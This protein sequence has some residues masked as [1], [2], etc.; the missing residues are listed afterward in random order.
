[1]IVPFSGELLSS[2][3]GLELSLNRC[4]MGCSYCFAN[5]GTPHRVAD[6][7]RIM[8]LLAEFPERQTLTA[9][10]LQ[11]GYPVAVSNRSDPLANSNDQQAIPLLRTLV[12][13][14]IPLSIQSRGGRNEDELLSF[15]PPSVWYLSINQ[16]DDT[17]RRCIE[18]GA[19]SLPHRY[20]LLEKL[21][22][23][24][25]HVIVGLNPYVPEWMPDLADHARCWSALGV[26]GVWVQGMHFNRRQVAAMTPREKTA[27]GP[28]VIASGLQLHKDIGP[29]LDA[30]D[31]LDDA[32][33]A[34]YSNSFPTQ[35]DLFEVYRATYPKVF[36]VMADFLNWCVDNVKEDDPVVSFDDF[37]DV[38][39][40]ELPQGDYYTRD[41]LG[42]GNRE[43][44]RTYVVPTRGTYKELL[45]WAWKDPQVG[46]SPVR[47]PQFALP[48]VNDK[49]VV[50]EHEMPYLIFRVTGFGTEATLDAA[51]YFS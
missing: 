6:M 8:R 19:T 39:L 27:L 12:E 26:W 14:G 23:K 43:L 36:P 34:V 45:A 47:L 30:M 48:V 16:S 32:G 24:G 17:L 35:T 50:D 15:L 5:L 10:L 7:P 21:R 51:Q 20:T 2:P 22:D 38:L 41:Y 42:S 9:S 4:S 31:M 29:V 13:L 49:V 11:Q 37:C 25:H 40:P 1:M 44:W 28:E 3:C 46:N 33:L 18:P